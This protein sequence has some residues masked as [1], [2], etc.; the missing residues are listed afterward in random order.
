M[1]AVTITALICVTVIGLVNKGIT[2][3]EEST[4]VEAWT[5]IQIAKIERGLYDDDP[6]QDGMPHAPRGGQEEDER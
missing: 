4:R 3:Y 6:E 1:V 2:T 5:M